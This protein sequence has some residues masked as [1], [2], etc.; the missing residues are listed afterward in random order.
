MIYITGF[1]FKAII[2][3]RAG[4]YFMLWHKRADEKYL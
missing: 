4:F 1:A 3:S 2:T